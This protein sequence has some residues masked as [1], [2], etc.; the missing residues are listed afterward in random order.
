MGLKLSEKGEIFWGKI[1]RGNTSQILRIRHALGYLA[2]PA[3]APSPDFR[4]I[5]RTWLGILIHS[6][7]KFIVQKPITA[8]E[9]SLTR[10]ELFVRTEIQIADT[11]PVYSRSVCI[12]K[13][14]LF[15][16][17]ARKV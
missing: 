16:V 10:D 1:I 6:I 3:V 17:E 4:R 2:E 15:K 11:K 9:T 5:Y 14:H 7:A 12:Q 8:S 13:K